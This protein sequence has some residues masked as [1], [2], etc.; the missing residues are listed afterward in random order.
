[1]ISHLHQHRRDPFTPYDVGAT[2]CQALG[3]D[4]ETEIRDSLNRPWRLN[5]GRPIQALFQN[6]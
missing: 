4:P 5:S 2:V 1:M 6:T 3:V